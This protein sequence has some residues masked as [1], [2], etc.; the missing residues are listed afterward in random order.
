MESNIGNKTYMKVVN[1]WDLYK[2]EIAKRS[3]ANRKSDFFLLKKNNNKKWK[4]PGSLV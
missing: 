2:I 3:T 1:T 4:G